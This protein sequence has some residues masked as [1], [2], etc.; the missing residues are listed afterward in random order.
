M[1]DGSMPVVKHH[2]SLRHYFTV[3]EVRIARAGL[4]ELPQVWNLHWLHPS[5][6]L[7]AFIPQNSRREDRMDASDR[8][9]TLPTR[10]SGQLI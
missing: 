2:N 10:G 4:V 5:Y 6:L 7:D 3:S 8:R 9:L 1:C